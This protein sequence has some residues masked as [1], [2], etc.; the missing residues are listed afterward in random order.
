MK[1][2]LLYMGEPEM[3][4]VQNSHYTAKTFKNKI[5]LVIISSQGWA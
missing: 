1:V 3:K 5:I 4:S 2:G